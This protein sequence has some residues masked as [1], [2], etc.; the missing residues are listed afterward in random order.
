MISTK[1]VD[2]DEQHACET[3]V[4]QHLGEIRDQIVRYQQEYQDKQRTLA[5]EIPALEETLRQL[6]HDQAAVPLRI[7]VDMALNGAS[8]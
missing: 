3:S 8:I 6:V 7:K 1:P 4:D 5:A 2:G